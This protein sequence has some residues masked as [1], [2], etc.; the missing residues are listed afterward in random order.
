MEVKVGKRSIWISLDISPLF[1][2]VVYK[3]VEALIVIY[4]EIFQALGVK[5]DV[6]LLKPF[7][8]CTPSTAHSRLSPLGLLHV[9]Q[10]EKNISEA[11]NFHVSTLSVI[12]LLN[13]VP[14]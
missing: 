1:F 8:D 14:F 10:N 2:Y 13:I 11:G 6:L 9:W 12:Y 5:G 3:L 7:L 4:D